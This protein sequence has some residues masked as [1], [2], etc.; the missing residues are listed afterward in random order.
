MLNSH[1]IPLPILN[2]VRGKFL[3]LSDYNIESNNFKHLVNGLPAYIPNSLQKI[4]LC[5]NSITDDDMSKLIET[6]A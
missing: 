3:L 4:V 5:N 2:K 6:I 1:N